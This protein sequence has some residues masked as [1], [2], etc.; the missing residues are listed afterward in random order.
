MV[1]GYGTVSEGDHGNAGVV[2]GKQKAIGSG[3][4][5]DAADTF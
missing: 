4:V 5:I 3:F 2:I 1:T